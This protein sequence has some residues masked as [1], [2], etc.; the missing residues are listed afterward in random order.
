MSNDLIIYL[1]KNITGKCRR[2]QIKGA[3]TGTLSSVQRLVY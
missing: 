3:H 1:V 2:S